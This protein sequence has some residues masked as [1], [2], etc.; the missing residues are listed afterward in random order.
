[1][2]LKQS[3]ILAFAE[4]SPWEPSERLL[5]EARSS[6]RQTAFLC[7]S[8]KD[9]QLAKGVQAFLRSFGW[10]LYIDWEDTAMP[11]RP[12]RTTAERIQSKIKQMDWFLY[13]ATANSSTSRWCPWEIGYADGTKPLP[14][15]LVLPTA[16][17]HSNHGAEYLD[18]YRHIDVRAVGVGTIVRNLDQTST[19]LN[20]MR[21]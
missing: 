9:R 1:M 16:D 18:L 7:H 20:A 15:I 2:A 6:N 8:H 10:D 3:E 11:A 12:D 5:A 17:N 13:L 14:R 21:R 19:E 4:R